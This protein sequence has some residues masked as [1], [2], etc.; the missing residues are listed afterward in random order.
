MCKSFE[1]VKENF[2]D[3]EFINL[4]NWSTWSHSVNPPNFEISETKMTLKE[5]KKKL[6]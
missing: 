5:I 1:T 3:Y 4:V 2:G 6:M